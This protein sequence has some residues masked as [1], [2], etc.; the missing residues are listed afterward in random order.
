[1]EIPNK[2]RQARNWEYVWEKPVAS[3]KMMRRTRL[4]MYGHFRPNRSPR[5]PK[6]AAPTDRSISVRVI[7]HVIDEGSLL[8][9]VPI[10]ETVSETVKKSKAS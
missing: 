4:A 2:A 5:M 8:N 6:M 3:S 1:M 9:V 10:F 7:P